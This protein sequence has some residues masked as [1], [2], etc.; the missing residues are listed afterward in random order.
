MVREGAKCLHIVARA[1][2]LFKIC[3]ASTNYK[4]Y[5][6]K[7]KTIYVKINKIK[8]TLKSIIIGLTPLSH[9]ISPLQ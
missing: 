2:L 5:H 3:K 4:L 1:M 6:A 8:S 7:G 9:H